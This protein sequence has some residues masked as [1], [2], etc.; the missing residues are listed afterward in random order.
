[1]NTVPHSR[2][3]KLTEA[4][5]TKHVLYNNGNIMQNMAS[6]H[7]KLSSGIYFLNGATTA[8]GMGFCPLKK[9]PNKTEKGQNRIAD[10]TINKVST[11]LSKSKLSCVRGEHEPARIA[12]VF[13]ALAYTLAL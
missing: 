3:K 10:D 11:L 13:A 5:I 1:M 7:V 8:A 12:A 4:F 6:W 2:L 9:I